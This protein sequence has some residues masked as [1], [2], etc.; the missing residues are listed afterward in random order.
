MSAAAPRQRWLAI[1]GIGEDGVEGLTTAASCLIRNAVLVVG[2]ARHLTL[3][4]SLINGKRLA[5]TG[6]PANAFP[7]ILAHRGQP[8]V[9]LASGDPYCYGIG[10]NLARIIPLQETLC[11]PA[12]SAFSLACARL[13]WSRQ[14]VATLSFCGRPLETIR[15]LLQPGTRLLALSADRT[16]PAALAS[17]LR[18]N[19]FG[20]SILHI[21]E[22]LGGPHERIRTTSAAARL[23]DDIGQL[24][25][26][27][28]EVAADQAAAIIPLACGL[29][30]QFFEHDGQITKRE[31]RAVTLSVLSP[32]PGEL[33]WDIG[34]GSG[35]IAIEWCLCHPANRAIAIDAR[36][37]RSA[38]AA[39]NALALGVPQVIV[40]TGQA[41]EALANLPIPDAVFVGGGAQSNGVLDSAWAALRRR[42]RLV[43]NA[44]T[45]E[46][47][48]LLF[49]M[50]QRHG[51]ALTRLSIEH[52]HDIG[53]SRAFR[54][55][56][57]VTQWTVVKP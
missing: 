41:P 53:H 33:L 36:A 13:G 50:H 27:A 2:G 37:D 47:Q 44:V 40:V 19:G 31:V 48:A 42:G 8:V 23:P 34:C 15:P 26:L 45:L 22:A 24:N 11:L 1:L 3:A 17:L 35:S 52:V 46:T 16:T 25:L 32:Y 12:P 29:T 28:I 18:Q 56:Q 20:G 38:R 49:A 6:P 4:D 51:G 21:L 39:R 9:V 43:A 57:P 30:D 55:T 5:W 14:E 54:P 7:T 10:S